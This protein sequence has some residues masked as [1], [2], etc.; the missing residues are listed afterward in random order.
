MNGEKIGGPRR[1]ENSLVLF[2]DMIRVCEMADLSSSQKGF[3]WDGMRYKKCIQC[4]LDMF[5]EQEVV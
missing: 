4:K 3:T 5:S 1:S 2:G